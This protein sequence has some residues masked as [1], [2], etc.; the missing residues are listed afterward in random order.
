MTR[1][2]RRDRD[3]GCG[4]SMRRRQFWGLGSGGGGGGEGREEGREGKEGRGV[5]EEVR[6]SASVCTVRRGRAGGR[7]GW[8]FGR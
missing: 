1:E 4:A 5:G 6:D 7:M 3:V 2:G 8:G